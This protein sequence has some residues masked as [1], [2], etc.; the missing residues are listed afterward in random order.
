MTS[1]SPPSKSPTDP[2]DA[3]IIALEGALRAAH[4]LAGT[5]RDRDETESLE[6]MITRVRTEI[7][8]AQGI[9]SHVKRETR[10]ENRRERGRN[11]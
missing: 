7:E 9:V 1:M 6:D 8:R 11:A 4:D 2:L 3:E 5:L 10:G